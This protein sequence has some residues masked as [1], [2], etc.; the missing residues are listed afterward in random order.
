MMF[1][2]KKVKAAIVVG[3][4]AAVL[5]GCGKGEA[6]KTDD[7]K[8]EDPGKVK[9][10]LMSSLQTETEAGLEKAMADQYMKENPDVEIELIGVPMN[11][12]SKKVIALN[13][14]DD[15]PDAFSIAAEFIPVAAE[16]GILADH[17][18]LLGEDYLE[19]LADTVIEEASIDGV[20]RMSPW[21]V[22]PT[23]LVYRA[24][25]LE[26][27][28]R[29]G[30]ETMDEFKEIAREFTRD[31]HW[32]FSMVGTN[33]SSGVSRFSQ[34]V[35]A[36]GVEEVFQD[37][38][39]KWKTDLTGDKFKQA[40]QD[41][42]DLAIKDKVVPPGVTETG[43]PEASSYFAQEQT[44]L[45]ITGSNALGAILSANP[46]LEGKLA[47]VPVPKEERHSAALNVGGYAVTKSC[48]H[49]EEM[50]DFL[51]FL[52]DKEQAVQFALDTGRLPVNDEALED[53]A[54]KDPA[55]HGFIQAV[56]HVVPQNRFPKYTEV[57]DIMGEAY[58]TMMGNGTSIDDAMAQVEAR[59]AK[60]LE[61][62]NKQ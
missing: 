13:T 59:M 56:N 3:M 2:V 23:G 12:M 55:F 24:D 48:E 42:V 41:F 35:K 17:T 11:E 20:M 26:E 9:L 51:K 38:S 47:S 29:D 8:A 5:A 53:E 4:C 21:F 40:L 58:N 43:Y 50:A 61:E 62:E 30:I 1:T 33:N 22:I 18:E 49:P 25:W 10:T 46:D 37:E 32:G 45:M 52:T 16:M 44:G 14:S 27:T 19:G 7:K 31:G 15:L 39:G 36:Y 6:A 60:L 34:F 54:F 57:W 28:N